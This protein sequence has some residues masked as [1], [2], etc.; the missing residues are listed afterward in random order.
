MAASGS[1]VTG[2]ELVHLVRCRCAKP[3]GCGAGRAG[4]TD[5][6]LAETAPRDGRFKTRPRRYA[7]VTLRRR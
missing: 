5:S 3:G 2:H 4:V 1:L 7:F 6:A